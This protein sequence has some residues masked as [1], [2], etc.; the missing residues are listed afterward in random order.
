MF[1]WAVGVAALLGASVAVVAN[2]RR[3]SGE[4][5]NLRDEI[6]TVSDSFE[7]V[8]RLLA[9]AEADRGRTIL[10]SIEN[11]DYRMANNLGRLNSLLDQLNGLL[12]GGREVE[13]IEK[14]SLCYE[15]QWQIPY[16]GPVEFESP[17]ELRKF[18]NLPPISDED[19]TSVDWDH[20]FKRIQTDDLE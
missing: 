4:I 16:P 14:P 13:G 7:Q 9:G 1:A 15:D 12:H 18:N 10:D 6:R 5:E 3:Q 11:D 20:L 19:I 17:E 8:A 2:L